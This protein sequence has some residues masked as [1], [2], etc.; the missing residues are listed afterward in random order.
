MRRRGGTRSD[1]ARRIK[2][3]KVIKDFK[4]LDD[5]SRM[6][7]RRHRVRTNV[8]GVEANDAGEPR[9]GSM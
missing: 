3:I 8:V 7:R 2:V 1:V 4:G 5:L 6:R 9:G